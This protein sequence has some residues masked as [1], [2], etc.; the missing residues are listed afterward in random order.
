MA[1]HQGQVQF[2]FHMAPNIPKIVQ[3]DSTR[4]L[5][6]CYNVLSNSNKFTETGSISFTILVQDESLKSVQELNESAKQGTA[7]NTY[8]N[9]QSEADV[10]GMASLENFSFSALGG[11][12]K[13]NT[14]NSSTANSSVSSIAKLRTLMKALPSARSVGSHSD[15]SM[16]ASTSNHDLEKGENKNEHTNNEG[17][18]EEVEEEDMET[19]TLQLIFEDTGMYSNNNSKQH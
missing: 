9:D 17:V 11:K 4:L 16:D 10:N 14:T 19:V 6:I 15:L 13:T 3:T 2:V 5:Q 12:A 7:N 18:G 1:K 8:V